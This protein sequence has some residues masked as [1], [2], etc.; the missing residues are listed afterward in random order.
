MAV[1]ADNGEPKLTDKAFTTQISVHLLVLTQMPHKITFDGRATN[2][3]NCATRKF[4]GRK[5]DDEMRKDAAKYGCKMT[6]RL[7]ANAA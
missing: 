6:M 7:V 2:D 3:V 5:R 1:L 4:Y